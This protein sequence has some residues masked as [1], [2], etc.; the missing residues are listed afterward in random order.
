VTRALEGEPPVT[1]DAARRAANYV[2]DHPGA[3]GVEVMLTG[4]RTGL[5][6]YA[7]S[8]IIQNTARDEVRAFVRVVVGQKLA[9]ATTNQLDAEHMRAT[10]EDAIEAARASRDDSE[11]PGLATPNEAQGA[12]ALFRWD[13]ATASSSPKER[14][15]AV[16]RILEETRGHKAA[17]VFETSAHAY[18]VFSSEG[19][20]CYDAFTRC[21]CTC[22]VDS[23]AATGWGEASSPDAAG[24]DVRAAARSAVSKAAAG[25]PAADVRPGAYEVVLEPAAVATLLDY[26]SYTGFG[27]KQ[28]LEG[29][30]FL[31]A[32]AGSRVAAPEITIADDVRH[33]KSVGIGFD[34]EG[35]PRR[36]VAIIED[37]TA[38][39][40]VSDRRT[41]RKLG[42]E[43]TGHY[44]GSTEFGPY[45]FNLVMAPGEA[46]SPD[47]VGGVRRGLLVT[48][49]HYVN[50]LDRR[51][52]LLTGMTRDGTFRITDG[53]V[54]EPVC[55]LRF[56]QSVLD[57]LGSALGVGRE[58]ASFAPDY[59][60]F[61]S[62]VVP[63]LRLGEFNFTSTTSH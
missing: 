21:I 28:V 16:S 12:P 40:P 23:G 15:D 52:T 55:N 18:S 39:G 19:I 10:A 25:E 24:V 1:H 46:G 48:R 3:E 57:A 58:L 6:R 37:G 53:E 59:G 9:S 5:T 63:A 31:A 14:A 62:T 51:A 30:S 35:V 38:T 27:A 22:L 29:E 26:L 17:G 11:W 61:G 7:G 47:L 36:R 20:D 13:E 34:F 2:L 50:I 42:V 49:F 56:T 60:A 4:S 54:A 32:L 44:S 45:A 41:A 8:E 33:P 43:S